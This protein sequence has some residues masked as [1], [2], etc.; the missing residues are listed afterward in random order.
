MNA[1]RLLSALPSLSQFGRGR[2]SLVA[3][4]FYLLSLL[5]GLCR[6]SEFTLAGPLFISW[7]WFRF[8]FFVHCRSCLLFFIDCCNYALLTML[9]FIWIIYKSLC[10]S[11]L[12]TVFHFWT[13]FSWC[14]WG[15]SYDLVKRCLAYTLAHWASCLSSR[16][17]LF[18]MDCW[19]GLFLA[20]SNHRCLRVTK[21]LR[22][23]T[24]IG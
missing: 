16:K 24:Q 21:I 23:C 9:N 5:F 11:F 20:L 2:F 19:T 18:V 3:I 1:C 12:L 10:S 6:L 8:V 22:H 14:E 15:F 7:T 17:N 4:S 13:M